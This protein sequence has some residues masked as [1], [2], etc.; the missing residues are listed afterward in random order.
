MAEFDFEKNQTVENLDGVPEKYRPL[1]VEVTEGD[2]AGKFQ[3]GEQFQGIV[4]DYSGTAKAL[5]Q[6]RADKKKASDESAQ[7]RQA[8]KAF[9]SIM[10]ELG[11]EEDSRTADGLK[12]KI[13]ELVESAKSGKEL[14]VSLDNVKKEMTKKH[15]QELAAKDEEIS[16]RD[17]ALTKHLVND[18]AVRAL[19]NAKGSV[20]LLLP[21]VQ[22]HTKVMRNEDGEYVVRVTDEQGEVRFNGAGN[23]MSVED[24]VADMKTKDT[25]A[26]AFES[27]EKGGTGTTPGSTSRPNSQQRGGED[28]SSID[29]I[30]SG[31]EKRRRGR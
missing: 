27:E 2:D 19:T 23:P 1:Y 24:F 10:E 3:I 31:L 9:E 29:K 18:V 28:K 14:K 6:T 26:R 4:G 13:D 30:S 22:A 11:I 15:E 8:L 12:A 25:F 16:K 17:K 21:H 7:R 20:E 5:N